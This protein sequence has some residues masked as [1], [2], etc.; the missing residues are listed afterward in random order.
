MNLIAT[1]ANVSRKTSKINQLNIK[2]TYN[3][4]YTWFSIC[5]INKRIGG[6]AIFD[7]NNPFGFRLVKL[8][9]MEETC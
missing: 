1:I 9:N 7:N 8:D 4:T 2:T 3:I 6:I 5:K